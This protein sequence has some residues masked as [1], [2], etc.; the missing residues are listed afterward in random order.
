MKD[1][2][3]SMEEVETSPEQEGDW[4]AEEHGPREEKDGSNETLERMETE[5]KA[6]PK[7]RPN[8]V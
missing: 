5:L 1:R 6:R 2:N 8:P 4:Q 3:K 7:L